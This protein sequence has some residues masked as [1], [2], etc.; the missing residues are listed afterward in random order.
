MRVWPAATET[1]HF[2]IECNFKK[3]YILVYAELFV[4]FLYT[5]PIKCESYKKKLVLV[6]FWFQGPLRLSELERRFQQCFG[7]PLR[8][9]DYGFYSLGDMLARVPDLCILYT[10]MGSVVS[11]KQPE[12]PGPQSR[13][14]SP[15]TESVKPEAIR[16]SPCLF[17]P[18]NPKTGLLQPGQSSGGCGNLCRWA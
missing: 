12:Q 4:L 13:P 8:Y 9:T 1:I 17:S 10:R 6:R 15:K 16:P 2:N 18:L 11:F 5:L 3:P 14:Q 7:H